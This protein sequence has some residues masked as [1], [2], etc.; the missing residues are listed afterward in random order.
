MNHFIGSI[1]VRNEVDNEFY[2][3]TMSVTTFGKSNRTQISAEKNLLIVIQFA[4]S[5]RAKFCK[6]ILKYNHITAIAFQLYSGITGM[7]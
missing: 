3:V 7:L 5:K 1:I 2:V 6:I 4:E